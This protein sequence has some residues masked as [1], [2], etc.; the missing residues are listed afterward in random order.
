MTAMKR[1]FVCLWAFCLSASLV[2]AMA[3]TRLHTVAPLAE[4]QRVVFDYHSA[5]LMNLHH[6]LYDAAFLHKDKLETQTC[7]Q[8]LSAA[9]QQTLR[10]AVAFYRN[11]FEGLDQLNDPTLQ[12]I[13]QALSVGDQRRN[14]KGLQ[15]SP[16][17][18]QV[19][20]ASGPV[21]ARCRWEADDRSNQSWIRQARALDAVFGAAIQTRLEQRLAHRFVHVP[22]RIDVVT[23]T[24]DFRGAYTHGQIVMPSGRADYQGLAALEML[25]HEATHIDVIETVI[26]AIDAQRKVLHRSGDSNVWH[27]LQFYTVGK[28]TAEVL[29][30]QAGLDYVQYAEARG[31][32]KRAWPDVWPVLE[33]VWSPYLQ[34][35]SGM[36]DA[37][38][39]L[40]EALPSR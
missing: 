25:Y 30:Q 19:L 12:G 28:T 4:S 13:K 14:A 7:Q 38:A 2:D 22:V 33:Q 9:E 23:D 10:D 17:L 3:A 31:V 40:L 15:L 6:Y 32:F 37:V 39:K 36:Q 26:D 20:H 11:R 18:V 35:H 1:W 16:E 21:Y 5:F 24:G 8:P 29:K 34:G 27:A